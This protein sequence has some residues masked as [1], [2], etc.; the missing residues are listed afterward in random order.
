MKEYA[1]KKAFFFISIKRH[2][3]LY[4]IVY[5][6]IVYEIELSFSV[7]MKKFL[8]SEEAPMIQDSIEIELKKRKNDFLYIFVFAQYFSNALFWVLHIAEITKS[9]FYGLYFICMKNVIS[10]ISFQIVP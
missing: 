5:R 2:E 6:Y 1:L 8:C 4:Y 7:H 9:S 3:I 10:H